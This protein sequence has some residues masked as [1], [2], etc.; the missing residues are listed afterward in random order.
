MAKD[1]PLFG[2]IAALRIKT[3]IG[4]FEVLSALPNVIATGFRG[5]P[6][7]APWIVGSVAISFQIFLTI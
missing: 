3:R 7:A 2:V 5:R 4:M 1:P 6:L